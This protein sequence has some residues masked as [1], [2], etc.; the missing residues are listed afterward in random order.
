VYGPCGSP[1]AHRQPG[2][3]H[4]RVCSTTEPASTCCTSP[5]RAASR[6]RRASSARVEAS[7]TLYVFTTQD[8]APHATH[9]QQPSIPR[10]TPAS[11][12]NPAADRRNSPGSPPRSV[13]DRGSV[14]C[15]LAP[16]E[17]TSTE[18]APR[19]LANSTCNRCPRNGWNGCVTTTQPKSVLDEA[20]LCRH[21]RDAVR[22]PT[23]A[24]DGVVAGLPVVRLGQGRHVGVEPAAVGRRSARTRPRGRCC[25]GF[26]RCWCAPVETDSPARRRWT[27]RTSAGRS[28][29]CA[30]D[31]PRARKRC[32]RGR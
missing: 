22:S 16:S 29:D 25:I 28:Q 10:V 12:A 7:V 1:S 31:E 9:D 14:T 8:D 18:S 27:R 24:V 11:A 21:R 23:N 3:P 15:P 13:Q 30:A 19:F 26:A 6:R 20:A 5:S 2:R 32:R 17:H 4:R